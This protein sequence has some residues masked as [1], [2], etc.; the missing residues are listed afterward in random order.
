MEDV[1]MMS[2][3]VILTKIGQRLKSI[4]L[5]QNI[6]Q[7]SLADASNVSL[8]VIKNIEKGEIRSFDAFLR[9]LRTLGQLDVLSPLV[10]DQQLSPNEYYELLQKAEAHRRKH[11]TGKAIHV[12]KEDVG[13]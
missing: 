13:W 12:V 10:K 6:T 2:D 7:K 8:S 11:A 9:L 1:Y 5:K 3:T 4:R